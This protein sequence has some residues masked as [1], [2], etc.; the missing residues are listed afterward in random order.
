VLDL[1]EDVDL[2]GVLSSARAEATFRI[3]PGEKMVLFCVQAFLARLQEIVVPCRRGN[4]CGGAAE[5]VPEL[6]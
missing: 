6:L 3:F 2:H 5:V 1:F 4:F